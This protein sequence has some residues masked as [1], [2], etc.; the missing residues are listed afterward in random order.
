MYNVKN[1]FGFK[2]IENK[3]MVELPSEELQE[4]EIWTIS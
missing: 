1:D 2:D 3:V 4:F